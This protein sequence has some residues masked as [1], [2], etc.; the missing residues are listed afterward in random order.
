MRAQRSGHFIVKGEIL[1]MIDA[2]PASMTMDARPTRAKAVGAIVAG[3]ISSVG[4]RG[5]F[6]RPLPRATARPWS[7]PLWPVSSTGT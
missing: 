6:E 1:V 4:V 5:R 2:S 3:R 7:R